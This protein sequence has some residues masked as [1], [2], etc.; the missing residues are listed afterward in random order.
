MY[1]LESNSFLQHTDHFIIL[2][3]G[4]SLL[5]DMSQEELYV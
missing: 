1:Q 5:I 4:D 2:V 3:N